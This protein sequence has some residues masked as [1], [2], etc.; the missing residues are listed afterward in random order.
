MKDQAQPEI[1]N[2][3][4]PDY[5]QGGNFF[6][7]VC[8]LVFIIFRYLQGGYRFPLLGAIRF[9]FFLGGLLFILSIPTYLNNPNRHFSGIGAWVASLFLIIATMSFFSYVPE[10]SYDIF[11]DRVIKFALIGFFITAFVT[12]PKRLAFFLGAVLF[13]YMKMGQ[14]GLLGVI[15]GSLVWQNQGIPRLHGSTPIYR[16]P[17]SFS[18]MALGCLPFLFYFFGI[19]NRY[20]KIILLIQAIFAFNIVLF[21]GSRTGYVAL[22][23]A[24]MFLIWKSDRR[25]ELF[26]LIIFLGV[27]GFKFIPE[28]YVKRIDTIFTQQEIEGGSMNARKQ[29]LQDAW[30]IF[31]ENPLGVGVGAFPAVRQDQFGRSQDTHNLYLE[32]ATNLG[33]Q[34]LIIFFGVIFSL[35]QVLL[36]L[37]ANLATQI[38]KINHAI[39]YSE[40]VMEI[41]S[42]DL[43]SHLYDL[44]IIQAASLSVFIFVV[45]RLGL[46]L[47]GMDLYEIYWWFALGL[48]LALWNVNLV[49]QCRTSVLFTYLKH[50]R[51]ELKSSD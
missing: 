6:I 51:G 47:F 36:K 29:I 13:A 33:L 46:G 7:F 37:Q 4:L 22:I 10:I 45:I 39:L 28:A 15:T 38:K 14:E 26:I 34:G 27:V 21:T 43:R 11:I 19:A 49:S 42:T 30:E 3:S 31:I 24:I 35:C 16:H 17:N 50:I 8:F 1:K 12:T 41:Y 23:I 20:L 32:I 40:G 48:T 25:K 5:Y 18:G 2:Y 9:E 44:R